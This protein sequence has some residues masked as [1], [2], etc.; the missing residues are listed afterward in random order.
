MCFKITISIFI[1]KYKIL[2]ENILRIDRVEQDTLEKVYKIY[3]FLVSK[4]KMKRRTDRCKKD[5]IYLTFLTSC[6]KCI[7]I[8]NSYSKLFI[9]AGLAIGTTRVKFLGGGG[10]PANQ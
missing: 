2:L 3:L 1:I 7:K 6:I 9:Y 10:P 5:I 4:Y 8:H